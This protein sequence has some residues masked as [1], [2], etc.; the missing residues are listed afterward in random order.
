MPSKSI[1]RTA[2]GF[3][4]MVGIAG[5]PIAVRSQDPTLLSRMGL[6][7]PPAEGVAVRAGRL[8]DAKAGTL[9][10]NQVILI[11]GDLIA[12]VGPADR[13]KIPPG[14]RVIDLSGATVLPGLINH[15]VHKSS[16]SAENQSLVTRGFQAVPSALQ[17]LHGGFT[18]IVDM[19][20]T[21]TYISVD[22][23]NAINNGWVPGPR[24]QVAGPQLNPRGMRPYP[25]PTLPLPFGQGPGAPSWEDSSNVNSP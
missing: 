5:S 22:L 23:R 8:F 15:H 2:L 6:Q 19:G 20:S 18:T 1:L 25:L 10:T 21:D 9:L 17:D 16:G 12:D 3:L 14:A 11:K 24:M 4:T 7:S 13:V